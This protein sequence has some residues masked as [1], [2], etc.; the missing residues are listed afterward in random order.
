MGTQLTA[1]RMP[2]RQEVEGRE[3]SDAGEGSRA[4]AWRPAFGAVPTP[5]R[6][7]RFSVWAPRATRVDVVLKSGG[8]TGNHPLERSDDGVFSGVIAG[9]EAGA[10]YMYRLDGATE[11]PDPASRSQPH[12]VH[13]ASRIVDHTAFPWQDV[14]WRGIRM[15]EHV[16]YEVHVGTFSP[17]GTF[18]GIIPHLAEL[19]ELGIT[20]IELMPIAEFPGGRNWG[21]DGVFPYAAQSSYGG[22]EGLKQLVDA[23]HAAGLAVV[24]DVVYNHMGPEGNYL[25]AYGPY[26]T[27]RYRTPWG[28]ALNYDDADSDSVRQ[29]VVDNARQWVRDFHVDAL[30]LDAVHGI[31]DFGARHVLAALA[32]EVHADGEAL[33]RRVQ[34]IGESDLNDP[35]VVSP[36]EKGGW[37]LDA[38]WSDDFHHAVHATLTGERTGYYGDYGGGVPMIA[39]ALRDR[40]IYSGSYQPSRRS[41]HGAPAVDVSAEHFVVCLQNHD[42]IGNRA[43][44]DR[45]ATLLTPE[46]RSLGAALLLLSPYVPLLYMGEE[47]GETRPF[48]YFISHGDPALIDAVRTGRRKEFEAFGWGDD[49]PDPQSEATFHASKLDRTRASQPPHRELRK[50]YAALLNL[51]RTEPTLVPGAGVVDVADGGEAAGWITMSFAVAGNRRLLAMFNVAPVPMDVP[52]PEGAPPRPPSGVAWRLVIATD[53]DQFGGPGGTRTAA[54]TLAGRS[55]IPLAAWTAALYRLESDTV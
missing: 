46:Q 54:S 15:A 40:F 22:P 26:F 37:G 21:Y 28:L 38:Q 19:R 25:G 33:G 16:I 44:G 24:L 27:E 11:L 32:A 43:A 31:Y 49:V 4:P 50:L 45:L 36:V 18:A 23:A 3:A 39:R 30:R 17:E 51:R 41:R 53:D 14:G 13:G 5:D 1:P 35:R 9:A 52:V 55:S 42:Q 48:Q 20:S 47:Y 10:D 2:S 12:G 7:T 6:A 34:V 8:A 29:F